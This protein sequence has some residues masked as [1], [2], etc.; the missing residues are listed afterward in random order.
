MSENEINCRAWRIVGFDRFHT[1]QTIHLHLKTAAEKNLL[2][3]LQISRIIT[4]FLSPSTTEIF[5]TA[6]LNG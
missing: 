1:E 2:Y 3:L 5:L 6:A 4:A